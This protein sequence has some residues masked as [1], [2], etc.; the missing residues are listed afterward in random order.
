MGFLWLVEPNPRAGLRENK[1]IVRSWGEARGTLVVPAGLD[2]SYS[3]TQTDGPAGPNIAAADPSV[4]N[5]LIRPDTFERGDWAALAQL[6]NVKYA[7]LQGDI[8]SP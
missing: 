6:T 5:L 7:E 1:R 8:I 3:P 2:V 4:E